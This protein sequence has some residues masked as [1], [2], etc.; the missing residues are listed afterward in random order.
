LALSSS[1]TA[2]CRSLRFLAS[3]GCNG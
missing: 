1:G 2:L 3:C